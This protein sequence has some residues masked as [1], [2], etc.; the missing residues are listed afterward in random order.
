M[1]SQTTYMSR[2]EVEPNLDLTEIQ[3]PSKALGRKK[4]SKL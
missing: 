2:N 4:E 3:N 1:G